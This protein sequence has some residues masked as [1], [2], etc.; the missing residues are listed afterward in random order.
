MNEVVKIEALPQIK[1]KKR[2]A[3]YARVSSGKDAMRHSLSPQISYYSGLIQSR[4]EWV[5]AGVYADDSVSGT[6]DSRAEF[7][8]LLEDCR[9]GKVD[10]VITTS[11][12]RFARNTLTTLEAVRELKEKGVDVFFEKENIHSMSGDG[13]LMLTILASYAQEESRSASEKQLLR[14]RWMF[15][16]EGRPNTGKMLGYRLLDGKLY[17]VPS[18]AEI[19]RRIY[20]EYI[21]DGSLAGGLGKLAI[22]KKLNAEGVTTLKGGRWLPVSVGE[23]LQNDKYTGNLILQKTYRKDHISKKTIVNRGERPMYFVK[24]SHEPIISQEMFDEAQRLRRERAAKYHPQPHAPIEYPFTNR[25]VCEQCGHRY[26]HKR[27]AIGTKYDKAVWIC[28]TFNTLG[29]AACDSQQIPDAILRAKCAEI[30][31]MEQFDEAVFGAQIAEIRV[32]Q[33]NKLVFVFRDSLRVEAD[34]QNPSRRNSWTQ[35]MKQIARERQNKINA[36]RRKQS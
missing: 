25:I 20:A 36:E 15:S 30:L 29:K 3:A 31:G 18:E 6:K 8:R 24:E 17:I 28:G 32:P 27:T 21:G 35:E 7:Q 34:W 5:F 11:I 9:A 14:I 26:R 4:V 2:V 1:R 16:E 12:T 22:A 23:I 33:R 13:E 10:M 19:V